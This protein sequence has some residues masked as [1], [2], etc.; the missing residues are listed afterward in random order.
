MVVDE[1]KQELTVHGKLFDVDELELD[2][3]GK[4]VLEV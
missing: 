1:H 4:Q 2:W 3:H